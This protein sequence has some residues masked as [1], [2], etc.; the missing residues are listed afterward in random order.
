MFSRQSRI[1]IVDD[2]RLVRK[3]I[4]DTL[5]ELGFTKVEEAV[6]GADAFKKLEA[7]VAEGNPYA[8]VFSDWNMPVMSGFDFL[9]KCRAHEAFKSVPII[10]VTAESE[11]AN[12]LKALKA[13]ATDYVVKPLSKV[14]LAKKLERLDQ[15]DDKTNAA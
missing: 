15:W 6:D 12:V 7:A 1:L 9:V 11:Q 10:M 14:S 13:G 4:T 3:I 5:T 2:L 8:L